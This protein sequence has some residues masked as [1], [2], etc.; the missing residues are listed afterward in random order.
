MNEQSFSLTAAAW[1][2]ICCIVCN[3]HVVIIHRI[4]L[5]AEDTIKGNSLSLAMSVWMPQIHCIFL[6]LLL[7][8]FRV[9]LNAGV[10]TQWSEDDVPLVSDSST[11]ADD[12]LP[13]QDS[14]VGEQSDDAVDSDAQVHSW[15]SDTVLFINC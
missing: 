6:L 10:Q 15:Y 2:P 7:H 11:S 12:L 1:L 13:E 14:C 9:A 3:M 4:V 5:L 8:I